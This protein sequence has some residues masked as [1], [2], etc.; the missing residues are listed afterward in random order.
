VA[1][2]QYAITNDGTMK[3][4]VSRQ[5]ADPVP[6]AQSISVDISDEDDAGILLA[7]MLAI[8]AVQYERGGARF[9]PRA[10]L[11]LLNPLNWLRLWWS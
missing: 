3:A 5:L 2:G 11:D 7:M 4:T 6:R 9:N 8:E 10:L 1:D